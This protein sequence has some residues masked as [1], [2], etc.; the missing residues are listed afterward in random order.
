M[1]RLVVLLVA[2]AA[3]VVLAGLYLPS[4]A[5]SVGPGTISRQSLDSDL[6]AIAGSSDYTC[7]LSEEHELSTG[8]S[9]PFLGAGTTSS[10]GGIYGA[11]FVDDWL[12]SMIDA[13]V[14]G[15]VVAERGL[16]VSSTDLSVAR[17]VLVRQITAALDQYARDLGE[18]EAG[19]GGSGQAVLASLPGWFVS[20]Q[21][22]AEAARDVLD[23]Q[24]A[25]AG[26]S[27]SAVAGYFER[28]STSFDRDCLDIIIV[29][30]SAEARKAETALSHGVSFTRE[31]EIASVTT[32]SAADGG[33][34][35]CGLIGGTFLATAVGKVA[36]GGVTPPVHADGYYWVVRLASRSSVALGTVRATVVTAIVD[37]GQRGAEAE[38]AAAFRTSTIGV[39]PRYGSISPQ[40]LTLVLGAPSPPPGAELSPSANLPTLTTAGT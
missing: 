1:K 19:C 22:R 16:R 36:A 2:V 20:E 34:V 8:K 31:A 15:R 9:L 30:T 35:G 27:A 7:F 37:A 29:R 40:H 11:K 4:D 14:A 18:T 12:G 33:S 23:A 10:K 17:G 38:V 25:G 6:S 21:I 13:E 32:T 24:A 28:H 39:D 3:A 26:L 5:A